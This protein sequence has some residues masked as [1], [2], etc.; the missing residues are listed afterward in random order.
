M[1]VLRPGVSADGPAATA[2]LFLFQ[3]RRSR[4][5]HGADVT[6]SGVKRV[7]VVLPV[8]LVAD[9]ERHRDPRRDASRSDTIR[10]LIVEAIETR[11][12]DRRRYDIF[13]V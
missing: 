5:A 13:Y 3:T 1:P 10:R 2:L 4:G 7:H 6:Q 8:A 12:R 9:I 11:D